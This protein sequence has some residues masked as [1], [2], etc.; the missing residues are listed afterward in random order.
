MKHILLITIALF[1]GLSSLA[2]HEG[3]KREDV[4]YGDIWPHL[5][6]EMKT[7][8]ILY[9]A[10]ENKSP[11]FIR[12]LGVSYHNVRWA[13]D[14]YPQ[15][16]WKAIKWRMKYLESGECPSQAA[17]NLR[18][19]LAERTHSNPNGRPEDVSLKEVAVLLH[20]MSTI[21]RIA[22]L[23]RLPRLFGGIRYKEILKQEKE[24]EEYF[25]KLIHE[26]MVELESI[27]TPEEFRDAYL[28]L[29]RLEDLLGDALYDEKI[30]NRE[31]LWGKK[32]EEALEFHLR[33]GNI[34]ID[35]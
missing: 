10:E 5:T 22:Y 9:M 4:T 33:E 15:D 19:I 27:M 25:R 16:Y 26:E 30:C 11:Y 13:K 35:D 34:T 1:F 29:G 3:K 18:G 14:G 17:H 31:D 23:R 2:D 21:S 24:G 7:S 28:E 20:A 32:E 6:G 8:F 12:I